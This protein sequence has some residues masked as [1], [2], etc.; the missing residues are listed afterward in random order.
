MVETAVSQTSGLSSNTGERACVRCSF[1][2]VGGRKGGF[3]GG[4]G[5]VVGSNGNGRGGFKMYRAVD[6]R[7]F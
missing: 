1:T 4:R 2:R 6:F 5:E 7:G 3:G